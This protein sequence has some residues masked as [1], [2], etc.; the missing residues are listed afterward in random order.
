MFSWIMLLIHAV[1][2]ANSPYEERYSE[3]A[4]AIDKWAHAVP[5]DN[6]NDAVERTAAEVVSIVSFESS[7]DPNAEGDHGTSIGLGQ[8]SLSNLDWLSK[9]T[10]RIWTVDD[11]RDPEKNIEATTR[12]LRVSHRTC[13]SWP[14]L[15]QLAAYAT[16]RGLCNVPEGV[17][18]SR[19]R[20]ERA[21]KLLREIRPRWIEGS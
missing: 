17:V 3:I 7:F 2:A 6:K 20:L 1:T 18:A 5:I 13:R 9:E 21:A 14:A 12:L 16:G 10:G 19:H 4:R 8:I 15:Q 11:L